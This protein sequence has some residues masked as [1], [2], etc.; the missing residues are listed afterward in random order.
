MTVTMFCHPT[1]MVVVVGMLSIYCT[2]GFLSETRTTSFSKTTT[3]RLSMSNYERGW[4][5]DN[6]LDSLGSGGR[7][8]GSPTE[9]MERAND[10][11]YRQARYGNPSEWDAGN[12]PQPAG[13]SRNSYTPGG[14]SYADSLQQPQQAQTNPNPSDLGGLTDAAAE[15]YEYS[16]NKNLGTPASTANPPA[17]VDTTAVPLTND[18]DDDMDGEVPMPLE[19]IEGADNLSKDIVANIKVRNEDDREESSQ[20]GSRFRALMARAQEGGG[21]QKPNPLLQQP[22]NI[23]PSAIMTPEEIANLSIDQQARLYREFFYVQQHHTGS[24]EG[25]AIGS[26][27]SNYLEAGIGF[28]GRKIG[29]NREADAISNAADVYFARLK[30]DSTTRNLA[31]YRGDDSTANAVFHDPSIAEI[32]APVNPYLEDQRKRMMDVIETAPEEMLLFQEYQDKSSSQQQQPP[33]EQ[34]T[35]GVSY[36]DRVAQHQAERKQRQQQQQPPPPM[37]GS[38]GTPY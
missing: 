21:T 14:T 30:R 11:Y 20:G 33:Q 35:S 36:R 5:N 15:V 37:D 2:H 8:D 9:A 4:D 24:G 28:D 22:Q 25:K 23:P 17:I 27:S 16:Y 34:S 29:R 38:G 7:N 32:E 18:N 26:T 12:P 1:A 13:W 6:F 10:E 19:S 31:R 3:T